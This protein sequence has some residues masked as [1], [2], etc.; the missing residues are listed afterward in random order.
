MNPYDDLRESDR[1]DRIGGLR[2]SNA[3]RATTAE[4]LQRHYSAGRL[5]TQEFEERIGRCY[6]AK[7][8]AEL[9]KL[10]DDLPRSLARDSEPGRGR[11]ERHQVWRLVIVA[12]IVAALAVGLSLIGAHVLWLAW[13]LAF[14]FLRTSLWHGRRGWSW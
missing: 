6:A 1:D 5:D 9:H 13:P 3:D 14:T 4:L 7:T 2:A 8:V 12:P 11:V 10:V